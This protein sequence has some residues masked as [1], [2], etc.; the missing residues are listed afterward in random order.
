MEQVN[1]E[2]PSTDVA[3]VIGANDVVNPDARDNPNR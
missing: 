1:P 2:F 3:V